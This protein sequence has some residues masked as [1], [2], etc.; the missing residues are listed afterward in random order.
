MYTSE[1]NTLT[2]ETEFHG[3]GGC[4]VRGGTDGTAD[5]GKATTEV[6]HCPQSSPA[7]RGRGEGDG[8]GAGGEG[9]DECKG[10]GRGGTA[11]V[12][13]ATTEVGDRRKSLPRWRK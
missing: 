7:A 12:G 1:I 8:K 3:A 2:L 9:D 13:K 6:S 10:G 4:W 5:V 11:D